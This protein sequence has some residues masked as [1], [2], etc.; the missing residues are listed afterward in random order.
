MKPHTEAV[1]QT[2]SVKKVLLKVLQNSQENTKCQV[3]KKRLWH[4]CAPVIFVKFLG[5]PFSIEHLR[6]LL[7]DIF[8]KGTFSFTVSFIT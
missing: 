5:T 8:I 3:S 4:G 6:C 2:C 7:L 1:V